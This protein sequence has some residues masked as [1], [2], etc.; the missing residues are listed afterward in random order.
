MK[1]GAKGRIS[2]RK[3]ETEPDMYYCGSCKI[4]HLKSAFGKSVNR[5]YGIA[6]DCKEACNKRVRNCRKP[7]NVKKQDHTKDYQKPPAI[8][9]RNRMSTLDN[10]KRY[11]SQRQYLFISTYDEPYNDVSAKKWYDWSRKATIDTSDC[12]SERLLGSKSI[13]SIGQARENLT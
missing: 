4:Y 8:E 7:Y 5:K 1:T 3:H 2:S 12:P 11:W 10:F 6:N 9:M 13:T